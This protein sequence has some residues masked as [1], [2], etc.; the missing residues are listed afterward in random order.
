LRFRPELPIMR[1]MMEKQDSTHDICLALGSNLGDKLEILRATCRALAPYVTITAT[2]PVYETQPA[3]VTNQP[4]FYN[5][6]IRGTTTL[7]PMGLLYTVKDIEIELGRLPTFRYGPRVIDIDIIFY[8][9]LALH[10]T[11]LTIPHALMAERIFVLKPLAD[12]APSLRHPVLNKTVQELLDAL[13]QGDTAF[14]VDGS[15][16]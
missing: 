6:V 9:S 1:A 14:S 10:T 5:A 4:L 8:D 7:D 2:S 11:E 15:L 3:Y 13:P 16:L 12:I